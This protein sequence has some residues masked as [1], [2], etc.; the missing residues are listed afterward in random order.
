MLAQHFKDVKPW[1]NFEQTSVPVDGSFDIGKDVQTWHVSIYTD[2]RG[3][4]IGIKICISTLQD[5]LNK[6][7]MGTIIESLALKWLIKNEISNK[8]YC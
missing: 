4:D 5:E 7:L 6:Y 8:L 1:D 2:I 3:M